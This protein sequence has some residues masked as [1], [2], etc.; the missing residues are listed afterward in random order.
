MHRL[1]DI[2]KVSREYLLGN[3]PARLPESESI[4]FDTAWLIFMMRVPKTPDEYIKI[5]KASASMVLT[6]EPNKLL[7]VK[8]VKTATYHL[9]MSYITSGLSC[10]E[11]QLKSSSMP[12]EQR[13]SYAIGPKLVLMTKIALHVKE[14]LLAYKP[15]GGMTDDVRKALGDF[16]SVALFTFKE[17]RANLSAGFHKDI[18]SAI[19]DF[20]ECLRHYHLPRLATAHDREAEALKSRGVIPLP[21]RRGITVPKAEGASVVNFQDL[22]QRAQPQNKL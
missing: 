6:Q 14:S 20:E 18:D 12:L 2:F 5:W 3:S 1:D 15:E 9:A 10:A 13:Y 4:D 19:V 21:Q 16:Y 17:L 8:S 11:E 22:K 7:T